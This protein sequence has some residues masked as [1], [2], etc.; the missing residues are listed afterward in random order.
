[1]NVTKNLELSE[2]NNNKILDLLIKIPENIGTPIS[3]LVHTI[4]FLIFLALP[5]VGLGLQS[6]QVNIFFTTLLS[7]EAIYLAI[8]IQ[9]S[10]NRSNQNIQDLSED[11]DDIQE[12][13]EDIQGDIDYMTE[14]DELI[15]SNPSN[16]A[17][18]SQQIEMLQKQIHTMSAMIDKMKNEVKK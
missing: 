17:T 1:M 15:N 14:E 6:E 4:V 10:V 7:L 8:F 2:Q 12:D 9:M 3:L 16:H 5:F 18:M 11:L 13:I